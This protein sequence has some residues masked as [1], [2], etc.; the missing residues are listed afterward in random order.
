M[1]ILV[2]G[3]A[4]FIGAHT[5]RA[6]KRQKM[7]VVVLDNLMHD[8][9]DFVDRL[10]VPLVEGQV[11]QQALLDELLRGDH[12]ATSGDEISGVIHFAAYTDARDS[13]LQPERYYRNNFGDALVLY[14]ALL[15]E[16]RR[17]GG[18]AVPLVFSS[19]CATY[20]IPDPDQVPIQEGCDQRPLNPYGRSKWMVEKLLQDLELAHGLPSVVFR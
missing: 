14:E 10:G 16:Y 20:G 18:S 1:T 13:V 8:H 7:P 11:G 15:T 12:P 17:R 2:T 6:L 5:V 9:A 4:G 3:G 19:T